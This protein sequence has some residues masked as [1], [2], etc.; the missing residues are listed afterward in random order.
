MYK[1]LM[2]ILDGLG[3]RPSPALGNRTPLQAAH[4]PFMDALAAAGSGGLVEPLSEGFP[5]DTHAGCA[6]LMRL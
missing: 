3:D 2:I 6:A 4:T 1:G 5:V